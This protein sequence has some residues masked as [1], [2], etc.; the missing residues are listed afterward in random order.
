VLSHS[1]MDAYSI[2]YS[3]ASSCNSSR[4][5]KD[6]KSSHLASIVDFGQE[7]LF[8][9]L[10]NMDVFDKVGTAPSLPAR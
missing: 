10:P 7:R 9:S 3:S 1:V 6:L 5:Y 8:K 4:I 2:S